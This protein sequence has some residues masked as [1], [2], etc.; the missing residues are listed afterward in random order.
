MKV[1]VLGATGMIG[2]GVLREC[3]RDAD[4]ERV[5]A[6]GRA[7]TGLQHAKLQELVQADLFDLGPVEAQLAGWDACFFCLGVSSA[8][9]KPADYERITYDL[10][11]SVASTLARLDPAMTFV[12]V[13]GAGTDGSERGRSRWARVKGKTENALMRLP[14]KAAYMFRPG[15]VQPRHGIVSKTRLYRALYGAVGWL[16]P[17]WKLL[18]PGFV[19]TTDQVGRAMLR[20][21]R[22]GW[23]AAILENRDINAAA[24]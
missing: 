11:L 19:T 22:S 13:S 16:Y 10:T 20:V 7:P 17:L 15:F 4:V 6:I 12:Y 9:M 1:I 24:A 23:T 14:F 21:A 3:L 18:F 2:Q 5:L 8:G